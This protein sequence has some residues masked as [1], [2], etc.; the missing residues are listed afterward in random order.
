MLATDRIG[1]VFGFKD[2]LESM[3]E[4]IVM[5]QALLADADNK[6]SHNKA[7][8]LWL[9]RLEGVAFDADHMLDELHY[10]TLR[11]KVVKYRNQQVKGSKVCFF[12]SFSYTRIVFQWRM[13]SMVRDINMKFKKINKGAQDFGLNT[14]HQID[15][16]LPPTASRITTNR[17]T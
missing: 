16:A 13:A 9:R 4:S 7:V 12:F 11:H 8:Q 5:I 15:A 17:Q 6:Q 14:R 3:R 2:E 1:L 10:E